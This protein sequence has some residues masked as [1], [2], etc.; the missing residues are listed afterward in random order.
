M[1]MSAARV[2]EKPAPAAGPFTAAM[3]GVLIRWKAAMASAHD[4]CPA[5]ISAADMPGS[6]AASSR[7]RPAQKP[8]P[9]PVST[10][11]RTL[12]SAATS[13]ASARS[14]RNI[15][16][17]R[18]LSRSGW[19]SAASTTPGRARS[20]V[21]VLYAATGL[22]LSA[23]AGRPGPAQDDLRAARMRAGL[24]TM[25]CSIVSSA[26]PRRRSSG[27]TPSEM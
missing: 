10:S 6:R 26:T 16:N 17:V 27:R 13:S 18:A 11:T 1:R 2:S 22:P 15:S 19:S 14:S 24:R 5:S 25:I 20:T 23:P 9:A 4:V 3:T 12:S 21:S 7:S 8:R